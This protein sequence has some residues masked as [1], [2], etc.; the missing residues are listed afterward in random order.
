MARLFREYLTPLPGEIESDIDE[1]LLNE[2]LSLNG[3]PSICQMERCAQ[4]V[5][6]RGGVPPAPE[7]LLAEYQRRLDEKIEQRTGM[8][9]NAEVPCERFVVFGAR[10]L[11]EV[12]EERG[13]RLFILSGTREDRVRRE[14]ALLDLTRYFGRHI[15]GSPP[16][17]AQFS[18]RD[19]LMRLVEQEKIPPAQLLSF[20]DGPVELEHTKQ[21]GGMAVGVASDEENNGSGK[22]D[23]LKRRQ[24][25]L[26]GADVMI[27]DY[28]DAKTLMEH[29]IGK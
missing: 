24:L 13:L 6:E 21:M 3:W 25:S 14:A 19:V 5:R 22:M 28:R 29:L 8:I 17:P 9:L 26:A 10:A 16:S 7:R 1:F 20:G 12:L 23:P 15:Y 4:L 27:A 18:K 2:I 11:L